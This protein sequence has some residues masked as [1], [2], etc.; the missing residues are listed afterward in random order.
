MRYYSEN[1]KNWLK[2]VFSLQKNLKF[3]NKEN[4]N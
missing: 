1:K 4:N 3:Y 2:S